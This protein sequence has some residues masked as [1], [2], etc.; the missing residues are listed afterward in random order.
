M[1]DYFSFF[2][3]KT[4][5]FENNTAEREPNIDLYAV[6]PPYLDRVLKSSHEKGI[7]VLSGSRGSGKSATRITVS[8]NLWSNVK[9]PLIVPLI[10][11]NVF[12]SYDKSLAPLEVYADQIC[13][14]VI[15][16]ILSWLSSLEDGEARAQLQS[17]NS[18]QK[19]LTDQLVSNFY[20]NRSES[21][22]SAS[23]R[24]C[25]EAL[26]LS[27]SRKG[28]IWIEKRWDQVASV[29]SSLANSVAKKY[30]DFDIGDPESY[31]ALLKHQKQQGLSDPVYIFSKS[32]ELARAF[33]FSGIVI[34]VDKV[35]ETD[36]TN[37]SVTAAGDLIYPLLSNIQ[38]HEID[39]LTWTFFLWDKVRDCLCLENHRSVR[40]DKIPNGKITW[41]DS[42]LAQLVD[43]RINYFSDKMLN[44][45]S[46]ICG[47]DTNTHGIITTILHLSE[48]SPRN[49]I[50][51]LDIVLS[52]HIQLHQTNQIKLDENSFNNGMDAYSCSTIAN[53]GIT[54]SVDQ[55]TKLKKLS[56]VTKDVATLFRI[57]TQAARSRIDQWVENGLVKHSGSQ[58]G[59]SGGRPV[60]QFS[61]SDPRLQRII[62]RNLPV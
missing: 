2:G 25:F 50:T 37:T 10:G 5:P 43:K 62:E 24:E 3:F 23:G 60:D 26:D 57:S 29:V 59:P 19:S 16:Q 58:V 31:A 32:V 18:S 14:L 40:W 48:K 61:V 8:K 28:K 22:R 55:L 12:R 35:D 17:L 47:N 49:L 20:L 51:L 45:F 39:G 15:E 27:L 56:F 46:D 54:S 30:C 1:Q 41:T 13:F 34:H 33:G 7:F 11:F 38:L 9:K 42:Y 52:E 21:T 6:R 4:N 44:N 36:W 53:L